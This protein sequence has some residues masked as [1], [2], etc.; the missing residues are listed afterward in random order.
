MLYWKKTSRTGAWIGMLG[1]FIFT[2]G[3]YILIYYKTA[4]QLIGS[5]LTNN[6]LI[7]MLDPIFIGLPL[8]FILTFVFSIIKKQDKAE[9]E[10]MKLAFEN[11]D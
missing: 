10:S 9:I 11:I 8:S 1:G 4:P 2:M 5:T 3:W 7:N 6:Y